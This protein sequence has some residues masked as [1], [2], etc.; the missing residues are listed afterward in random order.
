MPS[1]ARAI[2]GQ[3]LTS[4]QYP[5][6][7]LLTL[8]HGPPVC[9]AHEA[10]LTSAQNHCSASTSHMLASSRRQRTPSMPTTK[11]NDSASSTADRS[12]T[13]LRK[14]AAELIRHPPLPG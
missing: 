2:A 13:Q 8:A 12:A 4:G 3:E 6:E 14:S 10:D 7:W 11:L 1:R 9:L 5:V